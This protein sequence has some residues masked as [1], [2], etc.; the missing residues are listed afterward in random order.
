MSFFLFD[1]EEGKEDIFSRELSLLQKEICFGKFSTWPN[2]SPPIRSPGNV[3]QFEY[4]TPTCLSYHKCIFLLL[5][6]VNFFLQDL[7]YARDELA[8]H[9]TNFSVDISGKEAEIEA[10]QWELTSLK[11]RFVIK[12]YY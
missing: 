1:L 2:L 6:I 11:V 8:R 9:K 7:S 3:P 5:S 12:N 4:P 10:L